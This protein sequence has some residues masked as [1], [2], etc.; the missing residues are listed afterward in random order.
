M[1]VHLLPSDKEKR[2]SNLILK[3]NHN[4]IMTE[5]YWVDTAES[6]TTCIQQLENASFLA[7]D[8]EF[9][10]RST[11]HPILCLVQVMTNTGDIFI[12]D[13]CALGDLTPLWQCLQRINAI[14]VFHDSRQDL[15][16]V[17]HL[18]GSIPSP[19]FDTQLAALLLGYGE[20]CGFGR[21]IEGELGIVLPKDQ[22]AS[23]WCQRPLTSAQIQYAIDDVLYL[24]RAYP[25]LI[26]QLQ[27][28]KKLSWLSEDNL[29]LENPSL[30]QSDISS[31]R[32]KLKAP[33]FFKH[34][35]RQRL[36][37]LLLWREEIAIQTD[38]PR[39]WIADNTVL[40][41]LA[42]QMPRH[43][44]DLH[45]SGLSP[46]IVRKH[47]QSVLALLKHPPHYEEP[48]VL[49]EIQQNLLKSLRTVIDQLAMEHELRQSSALAGKEDLTYWLHSG[50]RPD[51]LTKGWRS[52]L[53]T[54]GNV[55][56]F[57]AGLHRDSQILI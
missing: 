41:R 35:Q 30:Y 55:D 40:I 15:E 24:A 3:S 32:K 5:H 18:S 48:P 37:A 9:V 14:K 19:I 34:L 39:Q 43:L 52:A 6:L 54:Q 53:L 1:Q 16:I 8:T 44:D 22:T 26:E 23:D 10:R 11:Y 51:K 12:I 47:G 49:P 57:V 38:K 28:Q 42:D 56:E 2:Y 17:W 50:K 36:D 4:I 31:L 46:Q 45:A 27:E 29:A 25:Q 7:L 13:A 20:S 33:P 21:M